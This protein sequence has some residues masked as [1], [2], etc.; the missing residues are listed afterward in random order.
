VS[1]HLCAM[2]QQPARKG[3]ARKSA[4]KQQHAKE[5]ELDGHMAH[6]K[7]V[8]GSNRCTCM[9]P[10]E[11]IS[12]SIKELARAPIS[13]SLNLFV[14]CKQLASF[15][16]GEPKQASNKELAEQPNIHAQGAQEF[17]TTDI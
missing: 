7:P 5:G 14:A 4:G 1:S 13:L 9:K 10:G 12:C 8:R 17:M 15:D 11:H 2:H 3:K 16:V 6:R